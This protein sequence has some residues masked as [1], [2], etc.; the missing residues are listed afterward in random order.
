MTLADNMNGPSWCIW[1]VFAIF[2]IL[3]ITFLSGLGA[4]LI[5]GYNT[6]NKKDQEKY[7]AKKLCR[8]MGGGMAGITV[9]ILIMAAGMNVLP[10]YFVYV[11]LFVFHFIIS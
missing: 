10:A 4:W 8:V 3:T 11:F 2:L 5:A 9:L 6:A 7:D 1:A